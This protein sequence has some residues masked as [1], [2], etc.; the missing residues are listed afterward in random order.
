MGWLRR[1]RGT[2]SRAEGDFDEERR[3]HIEE[4]TDEFVRNGMSQEEARRVALTRF[5]NATLAKEQIHDVD[6]FRWIDDLRR[7]TSYALRMLWRSPG[8]TLLAIV[9]LTLGIGANVVV[10]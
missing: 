5:G 4:R 9:C 8:S 7:D 3:F 1:L 6:M 10:F 2:F